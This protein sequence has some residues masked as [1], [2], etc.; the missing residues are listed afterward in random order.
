MSASRV[1]VESLYDEEIKALLARRPVLLL[2]IGAVESHADHLP[3]GTDNILA[4]RLVECLVERLAGAVPVIVLPLLPFG[5]VWSLADAPGS[6]SLSAETIS[7]TLVEIGLSAK[8]KGLATIAAVNAHYGNVAALREAQRLLK[9]KAFTLAIFTYPGASEVVESVRERPV[10]HPGFM[11]ACEIETS[12]MLHLAPENVR[13]ERAA[14]NYPT[15]PA[16]FGQLAYR[17]SEFS[18]SPVLGD[19]RAATP[20]KGMAILDRVVERMAQLTTNLYA[21]QQVA[22]WK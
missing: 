7:R 18:N 14:E 22:D 17:W 6:F 5:Q 2:P 20:A 12:Y 16:D 21:R 8:A 3:A 4:R 1:A 19:P 15:F 13:M 11:H 9:E 10:A